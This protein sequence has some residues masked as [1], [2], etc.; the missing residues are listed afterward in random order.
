MTVCSISFQSQLPLLQLISWGC[1]S[2]LTE[3]GGRKWPLGCP[4]GRWNVMKDPLWYPATSQNMT[5]FFTINI[6]CWIS[7]VFTHLQ[8]CCLWVWS[9]TDGFNRVVQR[10][11]FCR[12]CMEDVLTT[13]ACFQGRNCLHNEFSTILPADLQL[14]KCPSRPLAGPGRENNV[15][16]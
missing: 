14:H 7:D 9:E 8:T 2:L 3:R 10:G 1:R 13:V 4:Y 6:S 15:T 5:R 12:V 11:A 16:V